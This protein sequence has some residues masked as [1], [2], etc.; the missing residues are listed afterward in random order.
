[1]LE[2]MLTFIYFYLLIYIYT[3]YNKILFKLKLFTQIYINN[4]KFMIKS[5]EFFQQIR[6]NPA[7]KS[8]LKNNVLNK[9]PE[10]QYNSVF[11]HLFLMV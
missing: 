2:L 6:S 4:S 11:R 7:R 9:Y 1:M 3:S 5:L 8:N 10:P